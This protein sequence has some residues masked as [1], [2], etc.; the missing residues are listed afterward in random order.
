MLVLQLLTTRGFVVSNLTMA[1]FIRLKSV[2]PTALMSTLLSRL[3]RIIVDLVRIVPRLSSVWRQVLVVGVSLPAVLVGVVVVNVGAGVRSGVMILNRLADTAGL[4]DLLRFVV[5]VIVLIAVLV[6]GLV[7][8]RFE[9]VVLVLV[10]VLLLC[11]LLTKS[12]LCA[13]VVVP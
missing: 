3:D 12:V 9:L 2:L 13:R 11:L 4:L 5:V 7:L 10:D 8:G 1:L 6:M